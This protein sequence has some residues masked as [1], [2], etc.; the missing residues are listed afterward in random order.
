MFNDN[1][2]RLAFL[3]NTLSQ[4]YNIVFFISFFILS[5]VINYATSVES[6]LVS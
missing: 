4:A 6:V 5:F 1:I 3:N 2:I